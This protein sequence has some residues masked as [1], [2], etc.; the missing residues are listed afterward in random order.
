LNT[1]LKRAEVSA[2]KSDLAK[3]SSAAQ[4]DLGFF[5]LLSLI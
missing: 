1:L 4:S 2:A 5:L 3:G